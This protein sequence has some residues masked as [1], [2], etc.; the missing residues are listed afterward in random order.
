MAAFNPTH[1]VPGHGHATDMATAWRDS[2]DY[3]VNLRI[4]IGAPI[5]AGGSIIDAPEIDQSAWENLIEFESLV[6]RNAQTTYEQME[7][8]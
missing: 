1:I 8:E 4:Q 6:G 5:D 2:Y 7:W 3:L